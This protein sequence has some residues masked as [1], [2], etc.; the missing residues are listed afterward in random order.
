MYT[1][2]ECYLSTYHPSPQLQT[3]GPKNI[4][5]IFHVLIWLRQPKMLLV[6]FIGSKKSPPAL[7]DSYPYVIGQTP[8]FNNL[9]LDIHKWVLIPNTSFNPVPHKSN[10][11]VKIISNLSSLRNSKA[12]LCFAKNAKICFIFR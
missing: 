6:I 4:M 10:C 3:E 2:G 1:E 5:V 7:V 12:L 11:S 9:Y 8:L